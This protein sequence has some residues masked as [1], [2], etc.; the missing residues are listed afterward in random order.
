[1]LHSLLTWSKSRAARWNGPEGWCPNGDAAA[2][3]ACQRGG[4]TRI[5]STSL[6]V[7]LAVPVE[8]LTSREVAQLAR[9]ERGDLD[10]SSAA[11]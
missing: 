10:M 8:G 7:G 11:A 3:D 9:V 1:M 5:P 2:G 6:R 4:F